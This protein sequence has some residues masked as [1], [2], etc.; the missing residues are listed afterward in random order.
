MNFFFTKSQ[1]L[2]SNSAK[3]KVRGD[4]EIYIAFIEDLNDDGS[5]RAARRSSV[6]TEEEEGTE[7]SA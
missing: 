7:V 3:S 2:F 4:L 5:G 1:Q 6:E